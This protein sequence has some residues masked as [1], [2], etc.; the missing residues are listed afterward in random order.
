MNLVV[1]VLL[2][3]VG[4]TGLEGLVYIATLAALVWEIYLLA[5]LSMVLPIVAVE[6]SFNP[7]RALRSA[8][9]LTRG[10][11][12]RMLAFYTLLALGAFALLVVVLLLTGLILSLGGPQVAETGSTLVMAAALTAVVTLATTVMAAIHRQLRRLE[13]ST[14][15]VPPSSSAAS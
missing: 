3:V 5:R 4:L 14:P 10:M 8:W 1:G 13:R 2:L 9:E 7:F 12:G 15:S 6:G 11:G